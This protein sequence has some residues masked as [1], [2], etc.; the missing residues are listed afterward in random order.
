MCIEIS[1]RLYFLNSLSHVLFHISRFLQ[2]KLFMAQKF[3]FQNILVGVK[4]QYTLFTFLTS[5]LSLA[6]IFSPF[7]NEFSAM[8]SMDRL[9]LKKYIESVKQQSGN[10][11]FETSIN[12]FRTNKNICCFQTF[13][14]FIKHKIDRKLLQFKFSW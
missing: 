3:V 9:R 11:F 7:L 8:L 14:L 6:R 12:T 13:F 4:T 5:F 1:S 10:K 2:E